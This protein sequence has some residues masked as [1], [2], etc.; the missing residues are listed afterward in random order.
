MQNDNV[1]NTNEQVNDIQN[2]IQKE[3]LGLMLTVSHLTT[4]CIY[5]KDFLSILQRL[6]EFSFIFFQ[7][8]LLKYE[9]NNHLP[10]GPSTTCNLH[11][12]KDY[13]L[14]AGK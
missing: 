6:I 5:D 4:Y 11:S 3:V 2:G 10:M 7:T 9:A 13:C 14:K 8:A 1:I 12:K